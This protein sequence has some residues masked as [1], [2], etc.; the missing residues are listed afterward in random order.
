MMVKHIHTGLGGG[1]GLF[2]QTSQQQTGLGGLSTVV[3]STGGLFSQPQ[4]QTSGLFSGGTNT[5]GG[6]L[7]ATGGYYVCAH[8]H[9]HSTVL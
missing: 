3:S 7:G 2:T 8:L 6:G 4:G 9:M 5:L 1:G